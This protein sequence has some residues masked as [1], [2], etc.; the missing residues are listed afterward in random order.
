MKIE[1]APVA[2]E[3]RGS[4]WSLQEIRCYE[5]GVPQTCDHLRRVPYRKGNDNARM[6]DFC[7]FQMSH[8]LNSSEGSR[9]EYYELFKADT[10]SLDYGSNVSAKMGLGFYLGFRE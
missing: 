3:T 8:S 9:G 2:T 10:R 4:R 6:M 5:I 1:Q 7:L